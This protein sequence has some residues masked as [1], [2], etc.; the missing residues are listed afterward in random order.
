M[1]KDDGPVDATVALVRIMAEE[2]M[3]KVDKYGGLD[4]MILKTHLFQCKASG[5][6]QE[7]IAHSIETQGILFDDDTYGI[8]KDG[9]YTVY[10]LVNQYR[11]KLRKVRACPFYHEGEGYPTFDPASQHHLKSGRDKFRDDGLLITP[12]LMD[13]FTTIGVNCLKKWQ[14]ID[15][16]HVGMQELYSRKK[17]TFHFLFALQVFLDINHIFGTDIEIG[18]QDMRRQLEWMKSDIKTTLLLPTSVCES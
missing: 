11:Q 14:V 12:F 13:L 5:T 2:M 6:T 4:Q 15:E 18:F 10:I 17:I 3:S 9:M 16:L 1:G 8:G 7:Q